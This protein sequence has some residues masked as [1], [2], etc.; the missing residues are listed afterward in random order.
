MRAYIIRRLLLIIPTFLGISLLTFMLIQLAPGSPIAFKLQG[1]E[2]SMQADAATQEIIEQTKALYG[3]DKP[4]PVQYVLWLGR[5]VRLDFGN[6]MKDQRPV[7]DKIAEALPITLLFNLLSLIFIYILAIPMGLFSATHSGTWQDST[8]TFTLF[9]LY[10]MPAFWVAMLLVLFL[11]GG[12]YLNLFP[13][14]GLHSAEAASFSPLM[15]ILDQ[16][17]HMALPLFCMTYGG[18]AFL[19]RYMRSGMLDVLRQDYIRTARAYGFSE[20][21]IV[22]KYALRNALIPIVTLLGG[23]LPGLIGGSIIIES[24]FSIPGMGRLAFEAV[25]S[26]DYPLIMGDVTIVALLTLAGLLLSDILYVFV[27]PRIKL[28]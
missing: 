9:L 19:S 23:L 11:G 6:S 13:I 28:G 24:I 3:L 7:M 26:R 16:L 17:W 22:W 12:E 20:R 5:M 18:L 25:L 10:S 14:Q 15:R 27:D 21:T 4:I 8:L 1:M 2:G